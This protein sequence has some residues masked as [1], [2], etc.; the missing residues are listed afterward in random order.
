MELGY[1]GL[2]YE[3]E[4][5]ICILHYQMLSQAFQLIS[6][7]L[8]AKND[9]V[10]GVVKNALSPFVIVE[11]IQAPVITDIQA[12]VDPVVLGNSV[13]ITV[14]YND[15]NLRTA[16]IDWGD[17]NNSEYGIIDEQSQSI[18]W[19]HVYPS[20]GV[21]AVEFKLTD[22]GSHVVEAIHK[23]I[24]IYDPDGGFVTGGGWINSPEG[25]YKPDPLLSGKA[26]FGF[27][28]KYKKGS[29][30]SDGNT[31]FQFNA[32]DL[33]FKSTD[34]EWLVVAGSMAQF[35]GIG[36]INNIGDYGFLLSVIDA[37]LTP[38]TDIDRFRIKIWER[39]NDL[40]IYDNNLEVDEDSDPTTPISGGS[41]VIHS[42]TGKPDRNESILIATPDVPILNVYPNPF[43][44]RLRF[45][46]IHP[47]DVHATIEIYDLTGR[48]VK[49]VFSGNVV[50]GVMNDSEYVTNSIQEGIYVY[51]VTL[52][53]DVYY[54]NI[55]YKK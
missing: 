34:Y 16:T 7:V 35:K 4:E 54:G 33:H 55:V 11:D 1:K 45:E 38:S 14:T 9:I 5:A 22:V 40:V 8:S 47:E 39:D 3:N 12:P 10:R 32:A 28:A 41:I 43:N 23:Y 26:T 6:N 37:D 31:E 42:P 49:T 48:K 29:I 17:D 19:N 51:R 50:G 25:A 52:G 36:T 20:P 24:V 15:N 46:F 44:G 30:I 21:Y 18:C 13:S 2:T 27:V 53:K